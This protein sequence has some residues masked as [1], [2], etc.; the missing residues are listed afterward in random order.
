MKKWIALLL[1]AS[2]ASFAN[3]STLTGQAL[4]VRANASITNPGFARVSIQMSGSTSCAQNG[5]Y[6]FEYPDSG[7]GA[8]I[9]KVWAES[10]L[11]ALAHGRQ[12]RMVGNGT[13]DG[14][15][16]ETIFYIDAL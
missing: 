12:I 3:A 15:G 11:S 13:C 4:D 16:L 6:A 7:S 9:G 10:L 2:A 8:A 5:W 14:F 1:L